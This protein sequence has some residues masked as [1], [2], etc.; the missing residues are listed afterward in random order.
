MRY[1]ADINRLLLAPQYSVW[2]KTI[3]TRDSTN[4]GSNSMTLSKIRARVK[5]Q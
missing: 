3:K 2:K 5:K 4:G 1:K